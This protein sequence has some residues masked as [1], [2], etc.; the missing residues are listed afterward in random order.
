[1]V[2]P[3]MV[4]LLADPSGSYTTAAALIA[5]V[6]ASLRRHHG[7]GLEGQRIVIVGGTGPAGRVAGVIA[8]SAGAEVL[9]SSRSG[10]DAAEA[11]ARATGRRFGVSLRGLA[12]S[13]A[14][15]LG[16][17]LAETDVLLACAAAGMQVVT[18]ETLRSAKRLRS[19]PTSMRYRPRA[20]RAWVRWTIPSRCPGRPRSA[21]ARFR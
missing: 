21:S 20:S 6:E 11:A 19:R 7:H 2:E 17:A 15:A 16:A 8:A 3:F 1:M 4:S 10:I 14:P 13:D 18:S 9:L 5:C 12:G